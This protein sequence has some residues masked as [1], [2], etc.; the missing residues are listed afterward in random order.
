MK[1]REFTCGSHGNKFGI[2]GNN[3]VNCGSA[4]TS[5]DLKNYSTSLAGDSL[6]LTT[7]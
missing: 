5:E 3:I 7:N 2:D 1:R 4:A 6:T